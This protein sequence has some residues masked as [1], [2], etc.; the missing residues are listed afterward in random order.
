MNQTE[1]VDTKYFETLF[2]NDVKGKPKIWSIKVN[3]Y[4]NFSTIEITYG[5]VG[6]KMVESIRRI[7]CGKNLGKTNE[8]TH[9]Q[10]AVLEATSKWKKKKDA[11]FSTNNN[12]SKHSKFELVNTNN[13]NNTKN[14][15]DTNTKNTNTDNANNIQE[16]IFPMLAQDFKKFKNK[17]KY[18]VYTQPKFDGYRMLYNNQTKT[19]MSRQGKEFTAIKNT[20]LYNELKTISE[21]IILDGELYVHNSIF[22]NLGILR[23]KKLS[24]QDIQKLNQI[25]YHV[26]DVIDLNENF[27]SRF[28]NLKN[29]FERY[30]FQKIRL[31][32]TQIVNSE[33]EL[34]KIH[35]IH[36][37]QKYEG[38]IVRTKYGKYKCKARSQD[39]LKY[40]DFE[41]A[42]YKIVGFTSEQDTQTN[43]ELII[44]I[45]ETKNGDKFNVRPKGTKEERSLLFKRGDEFIGQQI[46]VKYFELTD[47]KIP[48]FP[49]TKTD[50]YTTYIRNVIE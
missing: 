15:I 34:D 46:W 26:Y 24:N 45:C 20:E 31:V 47:G 14:T 6:C 50:A 7:D 3:Q 38:S 9:F 44:W 2:D 43:N 35:K 49:T 48:R 22:E 27:E 8:T 12:E 18:P 10:Q 41:D 39:L 17:L 16:T 19:V 30:N 28:N 23:K 37:E 21:N 36:I 33:S 40:K 32:Q 5:Y 11:G 29:F 13:T 25:E 1:Y 42:E 4:K